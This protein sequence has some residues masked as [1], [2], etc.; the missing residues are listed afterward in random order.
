MRTQAAF[1]TDLLKFQKEDQEWKKEAA[2]NIRQVQSAG[3]KLEDTVRIMGESAVRV[4]LEQED[5]T[6]QLSARII[7]MEKDIDRLQRDIV[8]QDA[9]NKDQW[10]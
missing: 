9:T 2:A 5:N 7:E 10:S 8:E 3:N 6:K 4:R 1:V